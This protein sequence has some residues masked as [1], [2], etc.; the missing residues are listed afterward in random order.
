[1]VMTEIDKNNLFGRA[2]IRVRVKIE[3]ESLPF[4]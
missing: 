4:W 3:K 2:L 1:M